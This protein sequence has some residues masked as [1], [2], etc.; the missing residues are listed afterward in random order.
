[1]DPAIWA[2]LA[3]TITSAAMMPQPPSHPV[4]VPKARAAQVKVVPQSGSTLFSSEYATAMQYIGRKAST[5]INGAL[6]PTI[7]LPF[8]TITT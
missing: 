8:C 7:P 3:I 6:T 4:R 2:R 5:M 1:M